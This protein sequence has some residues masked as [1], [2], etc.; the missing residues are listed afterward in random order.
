M[1]LMN[2]PVK[3]YTVTL[4]EQDLNTLA[5]ILRNFCDYVGGDDRSDHGLNNLEGY[6]DL[7][8]DKKKELY[9][10]CAKINRAYRKTWRNQFKI[11]EDEIRESN[12]RGE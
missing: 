10:L 7:P 11:F 12:D 3:K 4:S 1:A 8:K 6:R 2:I 5:H 9:H